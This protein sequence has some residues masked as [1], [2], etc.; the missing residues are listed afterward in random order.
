MKI[1]APLQPLPPALTP[2][3]EACTQG[4][5]A[6]LAFHLWDTCTAREPYKC[7]SRAVQV[8]NKGGRT[9]KNQF[10]VP[11]KSS[12]SSS[13]GLIPA[14]MPPSSFTETTHCALFPPAAAVIVAFPALTAVTTPEE[15][16]VATEASDE[17]QLTVL[18]VASAG[19][20]VAV[21]VI[22]LPFSKERLV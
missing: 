7:C 15:E 14:S 13:Q 5:R 10:T 21:K 19:A 16:T 20:T 11:P 6:T 2:C 22:V 17:L 3:G 18:S 1:Y 12:S 4:L 8:W 9:G